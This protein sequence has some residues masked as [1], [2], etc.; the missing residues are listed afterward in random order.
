MTRI[1]KAEPFMLQ[2]RD[3]YKKLRGNHPDYATSLINLALLLYKEIPSA[4]AEPLMLQARDRIQEAP[5][6]RW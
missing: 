3:L 1:D 5:K 2:A 4:K 6:A